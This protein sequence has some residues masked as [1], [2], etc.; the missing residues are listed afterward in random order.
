MTTI[1]SISATDSLAVPAVLGP[2]NRRIGELAARRHLSAWMLAE[3]ASI[4]ALINE[5]SI[6]AEDVWQIIL[7]HANISSYVEAPDPSNLGE[8]DWLIQQ[9]TDR[10]VV[11]QHLAALCAGEEIERLPEMPGPYDD[12]NTPEAVA[13]RDELLRFYTDGLN[14]LERRFGGALNGQDVLDLLGHELRHSIEHHLAVQWLG[15]PYVIGAS[16]HA[17][18]TTGAGGFGIDD[19]G[20]YLLKSWVG[21]LLADLRTYNE[22]QVSQV[23]REDAKV[24]ETLGRIELKWMMLKGFVYSMLSTTQGRNLPAMLVSRLDLVR[25]LER[26][27]VDGLTALQPKHPQTP[28]WGG[29]GPCEIETT[30]T[31]DLTRKL[32]RRMKREQEDAERFANRL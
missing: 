28:Q 7:S 17:L 23:N 21:D 5:G 19:Q 15:S 27:L 9:L 2:L 6:T 26:A 13:T 3:I 16:L 4:S 32:W 8:S 25:E 1:P 31:L 11:W 12:H 22:M 20:V 30:P 29:I 14:L 18:P 10:A 24:R